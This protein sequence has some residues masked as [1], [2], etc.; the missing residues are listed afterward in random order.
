[1]VAKVWIQEGE[2]RATKNMDDGNQGA[3]T[4][5]MR[6]DTTP[7]PY[8]VAIFTIEIVPLTRRDQPI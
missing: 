5:V 3:Y 2:S 8:N 7:S 1:M 4:I 6:L